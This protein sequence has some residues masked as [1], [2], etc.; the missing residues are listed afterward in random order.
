MCLGA[1]QSNENINFKKMKKM[2]KIEVSEVMSNIPIPPKTPKRKVFMPVVES[3]Y[4]FA[5]MKVGQSFTTT[6]KKIGNIIPKYAKLYNRKFTTR[7]SGIY[8]TVW[9]IA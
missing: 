6:A 3:K 9:R 5:T 7:K 8:I 1:I 2:G 4:P